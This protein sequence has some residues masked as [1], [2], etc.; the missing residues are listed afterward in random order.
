VDTQNVTL[1]LRSLATCAW[2][3]QTPPSCSRNDLASHSNSRP[4]CRARPWG[5][6]CV[7][8]RRRSG[9]R[10]ARCA[11]RR[12]TQS[13]SC[14]PRSARQADVRGGRRPGCQRGM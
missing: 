9:L 14:N 8:D 3:P 7:R 1:S 13:G 2:R 11:R 12:G 4:K 6:H 5:S 10:R